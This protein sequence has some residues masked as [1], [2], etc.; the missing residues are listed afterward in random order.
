MDQQASDYAPSNSF[1]RYIPSTIPKKSLTPSQ[2]TASHHP[3]SAPPSIFPTIPSFP[4]T[5]ENSIPNSVV[6]TFHPTTTD[7]TT[8]NGTKKVKLCGEKPVSGF[9]VR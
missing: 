6:N 5:P 7:P 8:K 2:S 3:S 4:Q 9:A 1:V